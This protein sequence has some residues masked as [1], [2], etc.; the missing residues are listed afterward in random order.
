MG[1]LNKRTKKNPDEIEQET[2]KGKEKTGVCFP[3]KIGTRLIVNNSHK[4]SPV[5]PCVA[6][7]TIRSCGSVSKNLAILAPSPLLGSAVSKWVAMTK[8]PALSSTTTLWPRCIGHRSTPLTLIEL[9]PVALGSSAPSATIA[10]L[11]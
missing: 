3:H 9:L 2:N 1:R 6:M 4:I 10:T 11:I 5:V 7:S 8:L